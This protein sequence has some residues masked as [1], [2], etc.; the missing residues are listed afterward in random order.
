MV[1][2]NDTDPEDPRLE[3]FEIRGKQLFTDE[4]I[5]QI[6][7]VADLTYAGNDI[8]IT[9]P[10]LTDLFG[11]S[12]AIKIAWPLQQSKTLK[13]SLEADFEKQLRRALAADAREERAGLPNRLNDSEWLR[14]RVGSTNG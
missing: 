13:Q 5:A 2:F 10:I 11:Q 12:L 8:N 9:D 4:V 1:T 7:Y 3:L 14:A 6:V